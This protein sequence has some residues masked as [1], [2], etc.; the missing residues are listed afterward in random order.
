MDTDL[1]RKRISNLVAGYKE[2]FPEEYEM[3]VKFIEDNRRLQANEFSALKNEH[4]ILERA[5]YEIPEKLSTMIFQELSEEELNY[6]KS[7]QGGRWFAKSF[8]QFALA[9]KI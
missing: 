6:F 3:T 1:I 9:T 7:K 5:L 2:L 4:A 8:P